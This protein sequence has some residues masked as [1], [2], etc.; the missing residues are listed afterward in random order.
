MVD[1]GVE[2]SRDVCHE[3]GYLWR[4]FPQLTGDDLRELS[5]TKR[6]LPSEH[7]EHHQPEGIQIGPGID[8]FSRGL[9]RSHELSRAHNAAMCSLA[10]CSEQPGD[11][12]VS[13]FDGGAGCR[14]IIGHE[15]VGGLQI[16]VNDA[17]IVGNLQ[18]P[19]NVTR[20]GNGLL[21]GKGPFRFD[22]IR[23]AFSPHQFHCE[24][25]LSVLFPIGE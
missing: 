17:M 21:P 6:R 3:G 22:L 1:Q 8:R 2:L 13:K 12:K 19:N 25:G 5:T 23:K 15:E 24:V 11:P 20:Q 10:G 18:C 4:F 7:G 16:T 14:D 9:L